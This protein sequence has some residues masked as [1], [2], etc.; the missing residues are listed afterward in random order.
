MSPSLLNAGVFGMM[1]DGMMLRA[2][3]QLQTFLLQNLQ[4]GLAPGLVSLGV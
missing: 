2:D 3:F 1:M 4:Q